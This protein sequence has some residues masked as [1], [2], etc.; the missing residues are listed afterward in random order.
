MAIARYNSRRG[1]TVLTLDGI[2][3]DTLTGWLAQIVEALDMSADQAE[4]L[5]SIVSALDNAEEN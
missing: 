1:E 2:E 4:I 3:V 5:S